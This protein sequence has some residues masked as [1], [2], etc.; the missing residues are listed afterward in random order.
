VRRIVAAIALTASLAVAGVVVAPTPAVAADYT[1]SA[2]EQ[3]G[4]GTPPPGLEN[5]TLEVTGTA[6]ASVVQGESFD[7]TN[8]TL[9]FTNPDPDPIEFFSFGWVADIPPG[10]A[11]IFR[12]FNRLGPFTIAPGGTL[13]LS[14][15]L[16][17]AA[18]GGP[19][20]VLGF[21]PS[22]VSFGTFDAFMQCTVAPGGDPFASTVIT[23][24]PGYQY[25][26][27]IPSLGIT[28]PQT[29]EIAGT[30]PA[31]AVEGTEFTLADVTTTAIPPIT[32]TV[33]SASFTLA[34]PANAT[35]LTP[36]TI[37]Q[38]GPFQIQAGVPFVSAP[39]S[40]DFSASGPVGSV[41]EFRPGALVT[42]VQGLGMVTC[43]TSASEPPFA[44]TTIVDSDEIGIGVVGHGQA[45]YLRIA[46]LTSGDFEFTRNAA[47]RLT[48]LSGDG[49]FAGP[50]GGEATL[51]VGYQRRRTELRLTDPASGI[52][53]MARSAV[54]LISPDGSDLAI[55]IAFGKVER[56][57]VLVL[58]FVRDVA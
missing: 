20:T 7:I 33:L 39:A 11:A 30:A 47:G 19:G 18:T 57:S 8:V 6:P 58:W 56:R 1:F 44:T 50:D 42:E 52:D 12:G 23:D 16:Q 40:F 53:L 27:A 26:C 37:P 2:C 24:A 5:L 4:Q 54:P 41:I 10:S 32:T 43:T 34:T 28:Y 14:G 13:Q 48:S 46:E 45:R 21:R 9:T 36:L 22:L 55:G 15:L 51:E 35:S 31:T 29:V 17:Y 25:T 3:D 38:L 49:T